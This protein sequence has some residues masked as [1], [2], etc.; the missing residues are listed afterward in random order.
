MFKASH[1]TKLARDASEVFDHVADAGR[2][3]AWNAL[4]RS[5]HC[6]SEG[7]LRVGTRWQGDIARVGKV[8]VE[9][10]EYDRPRRVVHVARPWMI[11]RRQLHDCARWLT[12]A[13]E[14]DQ[15]ARREQLTTSPAGRPRSDDRRSRGDTAAP[16][17]ARDRSD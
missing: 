8:E 13:L 15:A 16:R 4:V 6:E 2:Q 12:E 7:P 9:L 11:V 10:I 1:S 5:M 3:R 14:R 17:R